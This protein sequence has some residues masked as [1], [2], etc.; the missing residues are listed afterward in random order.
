MIVEIEDHSIRD[1]LLSILTELNDKP[2]HLAVGQLVEKLVSRLRDLLL[3]N[4]RLVAINT[5]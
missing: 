5:E 3:K 2:L 4:K 1:E